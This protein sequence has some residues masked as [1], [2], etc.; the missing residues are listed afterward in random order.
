ML[1]RIRHRSSSLKA[2]LY[3]VN[4]IPSPACSCGAPIENADHYFF[5]CPLYTNQRNKLFINLNR[6]QSND[7]DV[8]VLTAEFHN[9]DKGINRSIIQFAI[10]FIK[11]SQ[12]FE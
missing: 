12:R 9:Y 10:T 1:T 4:I 3:G 5:E 7:A 6:L 11:D 2:N 8:A